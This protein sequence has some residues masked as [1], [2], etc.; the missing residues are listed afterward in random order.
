MP[1]AG[2]EPPHPLFQGRTL[3][4]GWSMRRRLAGLLISFETYAHVN[5]EVRCEQRGHVQVK[6]IAQP[7]MTY[8]V[9]GLK[10][11]AEHAGTAHLRLE[12]DA[13]RMSDAERKAAADELRRALGLLEKSG[14]G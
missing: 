4:R 1:H 8:A 13:D 11:D 14:Q 9:M 10:Q 7:I 3:L 5:D 2:S 12:L 6:S